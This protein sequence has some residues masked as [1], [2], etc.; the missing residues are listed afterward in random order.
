MKWCSERRGTR[1]WNS[2]IF[3]TNIIII[4]IHSVIRIIRMRM[5]NDDVRIG[6]KH[7]SDKKADKESE[8]EAKRN[9]FHYYYN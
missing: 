5:F 8:Q 2:P 4:D 6:D 7:V 1:G 9:E 3:I